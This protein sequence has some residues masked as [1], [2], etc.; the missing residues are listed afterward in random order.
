MGTFDGQA[1]VAVC[2]LATNEAEVPLAL[3]CNRGVHL[4]KAS[5]SH[6][7][8]ELASAGEE[9]REALVDEVGL[10]VGQGARRPLLEVTGR[11]YPCELA[12]RP[13]GDRTGIEVDEAD[14]WW[15][16]ALHPLGQDGDRRPLRGEGATDLPDVHRGA[17]RPAYGDARVGE[18]VCD[19]HDPA[20]LARVAGV[21]SGSPSASPSL[22]ALAGRAP[23]SEATSL[24]RR[25]R[26]KCSTTCR[27]PAAPRRERSSG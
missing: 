19:A 12:G 7:P 13:G 24:P 10:D 27:R 4:E 23:K 3:G 17:F 18:E 11:L 15:G 9:E 26:S 1:L 25:A 21:Q 8:G 14:L 2:R 20:Q 6:R 16:G 5:C 22:S